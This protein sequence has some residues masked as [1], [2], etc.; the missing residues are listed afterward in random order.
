MSNAPGASVEESDIESTS[1]SSEKVKKIVDIKTT[2]PAEE[3]APNEFVKWDET[4]KK[5]IYVDK[6]TQ[7]KYEWDQQRRAY[8][9]LVSIIVLCIA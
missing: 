9:P 8:L 3:G 6:Q 4:L 7:V 5:W 2:G 1:P